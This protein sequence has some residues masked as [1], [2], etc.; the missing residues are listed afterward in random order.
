MKRKVQR[1]VV[2]ESIFPLNIK[3][4]EKK[5]GRCK[6]TRCKETRS[7]ETGC[8]EARCEEKVV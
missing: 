7:K 1:P 8:K 5:H 3:S 2:I 6:E 4:Q